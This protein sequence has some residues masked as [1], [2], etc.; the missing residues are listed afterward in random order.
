VRSSPND[1]PRRRRRNQLIYYIIVIIA[2]TIS[3]RLVLR[4]ARLAPTRSRIDC[5]NLH[6]IAARQFCLRHIARPEN[7]R[8]NHSRQRWRWRGHLEGR[9]RVFYAVSA[10][11]S[12]KTTQ[13]A[14]PDG[15]HWSQASDHCASP[16]P[17][18]HFFVE[19]LLGTQFAAPMQAVG[20]GFVEGALLR[21]GPSVMESE[22]DADAVCRSVEVMTLG[23]MVKLLRAVPGS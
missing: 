5:G 7:G 11:R 10:R 23:S 8:I 12:G 14:R 20:H 16:L 6:V 19:R 4:E 21:E 15:E 9:P 2:C 3:D 1:P 22:L 17:I 18:A 13:V